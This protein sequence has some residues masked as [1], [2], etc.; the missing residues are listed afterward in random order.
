MLSVENFE[1]RRR[2]MV[3]DENTGP[4]HVWSAG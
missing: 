2:N 1:F 3:K 4:W